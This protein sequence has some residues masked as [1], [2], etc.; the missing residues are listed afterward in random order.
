MEG[1]FRLAHELEGLL[2]GISA[3]GTID[4]SETERPRRWLAQN[5]EYRNVIPFAELHRVL[6]RIL[7][8]SEVASRC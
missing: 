5:D 6:T 3:D 1:G 4:S 2:R 7:I 8:N